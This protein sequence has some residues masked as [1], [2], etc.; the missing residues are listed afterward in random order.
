MDGCEGF[1]AESTADRDSIV[2]F[3]AHALKND[4]DNQ[5]CLRAERL[6]DAVKPRMSKWTMKIERIN[7]H[8]CALPNN[9]LASRFS[10]PW[11]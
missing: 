11:I 10:F 8:I 5:S 4:D 3:I 9:R 7:K 2:L 6:S 1:I